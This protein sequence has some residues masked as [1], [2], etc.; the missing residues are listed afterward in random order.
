VPGSPGTSPT[1]AFLTL[2]T[3]ATWEDHAA[4]N[5][6]ADEL[7]NPEHRVDKIGVLVWTVSV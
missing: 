1:R 6:W 5:Y 2:S 3:C 4:G 7:H